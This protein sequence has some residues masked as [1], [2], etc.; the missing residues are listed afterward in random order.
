MKKQSQLNVEKVA[1]I[2]NN[3]IKYVVLTIRDSFGVVY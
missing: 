2:I 3:F 1:D